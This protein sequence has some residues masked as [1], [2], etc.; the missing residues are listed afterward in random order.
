MKKCLSIDR[1]YMFHTSG[2]VSI[3]ARAG[4]E[5]KF[6]FRIMMYLHLGCLLSSRLFYKQL[7]KIIIV[8]AALHL[9][10]RWI[11]NT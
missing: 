4:K 1:M 5:P 6:Q 2:F 8:T 7:T 10:T 9:Y 11:A 3:Q